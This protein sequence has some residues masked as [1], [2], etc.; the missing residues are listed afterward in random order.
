MHQ[1]VYFLS[2][3]TTNSPR[4]KFPQDIRRIPVYVA[5][6]GAGEPSP[7]TES[8]CAK[9]WK[10]WLGL[11]GI[12]FIAALVVG[13]LGARNAFNESPAPLGECCLAEEGDDL[14]HGAA[15]ALFA[16]CQQYQT[17][18]DT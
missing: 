9:R 17:L 7:I 14:L 2:L 3:S 6:A 16:F 8:C 10:W 1:S 11:V 13:V 5:M 15:S 12:V 4:I 18:A